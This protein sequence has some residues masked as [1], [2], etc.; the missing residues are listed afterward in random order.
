MRATITIKWEDSWKYKIRVT[1]KKVTVTKLETD[2][3]PISFARDELY[4]SQ[5]YEDGVWNWNAISILLW[6]FQQS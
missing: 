2:S 4:V 3:P 5:V 1:E 6:K